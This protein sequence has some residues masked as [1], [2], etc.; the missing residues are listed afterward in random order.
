MI[1]YPEWWDLSKALERKAKT[2]TVTPSVSTAISEKSPPNGTALHI[3][4]DSQGK[5]FYNLASIGSSAWIIDFGSTDHMSFDIAFVCQLKPFKQSVV[6]TTNRTQA[7]V[8]G[9]GFFR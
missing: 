8:I 7:S 9:K 4:S 1:G 3:S 2:S 5:F 6:S